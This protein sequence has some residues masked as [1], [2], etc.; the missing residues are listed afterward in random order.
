MLFLDPRIRLPQF[1][2]ILYPGALWRGRGDERQVYLT[3]DDGPVPEVTPWV[4]DLLRKEEISACFFCVGENVR[5]HPDIYNR[6]LS[7]GH[8]TGNHSYNHLQ[9]LKCRTDQYLQN[10]EKAGELIN[11]RFFRPPHGLLKPAQYRR[12]RRNYQVVMWD[13]VSCDFRQDLSP[14]TVV[15]NVLDHVRPGSVIIFHDS[16]KAWKNMSV[17]LP[18]VIRELKSSGYRFGSLAETVSIKRKNEPLK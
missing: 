7:E 13:L 4:L 2:K 11:S 1:L 8:L 6:I 5:R 16:L 18:A 17:A 10:I 15:S 3:F 12:L 14:E 9:G